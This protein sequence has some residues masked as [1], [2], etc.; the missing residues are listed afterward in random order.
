MRNTH[1]SFAIVLAAGLAAGLNVV[2]V[3]QVTNVKMVAS[4]CQ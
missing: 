4:S 2:P 1:F 3:F